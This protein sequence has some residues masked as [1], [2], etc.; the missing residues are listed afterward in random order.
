MTATIESQAIEKKQE[1]KERVIL[2]TGTRP[3][4]QIYDELSKFIKV[5]VYSPDAAN[6]LASERGSPVEC[7]VAGAARGLHEQAY[8]IP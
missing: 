6:Q 3:T 4:F 2:I 5:S 7:P 1:E 8:N